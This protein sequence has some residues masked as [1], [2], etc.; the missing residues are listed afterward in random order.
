L[1]SKAARAPERTQRRLT[2]S[3]SMDG[4]AGA[5]VSTAGSTG[6]GS[7]T[8]TGGTT[9]TGVGEATTTVLVWRAAA[10]PLQW[11]M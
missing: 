4:A 6:A 1:K 10:V 8:T 3:P 2:L 5:G 11:T 7:G 9:A